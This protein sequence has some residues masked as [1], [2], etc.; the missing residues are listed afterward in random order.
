MNIEL[1]HPQS[2][3]DW[4]A[5]ESEWRDL[6]ARADGSFFQSWTWVGCRARERFTDPCLF[7]AVDA[8]V[9]AGLALFNRG[10]RPLLGLGRPTLSLHET[11]RARDDAVFIEHNG[12]LIARGRN[13]LRQP[14]LA[15]ALRH[16][17]LILSG[18]GDEVLAAAG[19]VGR[20]QATA[21]RPAPFADLT[22]MDETRWLARL[23]RS[24]RYQLRRSLR[25]YEAAGR[26]TTRRAA[27]LAEALA[28]LGELR[29]LHQARWVA[30]GARGA[31]AHPAFMT[32]HTALIERGL[33]RGEVDLL[34]VSAAGPQG[35]KPV[36]YLY[37]FRWRD[38]VYAYQGGFDY[39]DAGP[40]QTP[41]LTCHHAAIVAAITAGYGIYD[42]LAGE[43]RYKTSL[44]TA[45]A[46]MYWLTLT[47]GQNEQRRV[48]TGVAS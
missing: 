18:V 12:P 8:G 33:P 23:G 44:G 14:I 5:L 35:A 6:E 9:V 36:G 25:H 41:G 38:R 24:T 20:C 17:R 43:A 15:A 46:P 19:A 31:F 13:D 47:G 48:E 28:F 21:S 3:R 34:R 2:D 39:A 22:G 10:V 37:N 32:F 27:D 1:I 16:G 26:L 45:E 42:F 29:A 30:R 40:H 7:R 11:G 4:A